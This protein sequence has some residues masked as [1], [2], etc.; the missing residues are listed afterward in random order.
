M[1]DGF[2]SFE[3]IRNAI[4]FF[5]NSRSAARMIS[6]SLEVEKQRENESTTGAHTR[7][8]PGTLKSLQKFSFLFRHVRLISHLE[9]EENE[10]KKFA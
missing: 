9:Y 2:S 7:C 3:Q 8:E 10:K 4:S 6:D 1:W 5:K